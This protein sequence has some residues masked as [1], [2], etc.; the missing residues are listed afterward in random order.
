MPVR[1]QAERRA[2]SKA[3]KAVFLSAPDRRNRIWQMDFSDFETTTGG[4]WQICSV[5]EYVTK[6]TLACTASGTQTARD[7]VETLTAAIIEAEARMRRSLAD[8]QSDQL[9]LA[10]S[11]KRLTRMLMDSAEFSARSRG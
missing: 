9:Y 6:Y 11:C 3:R 10:I 1:Y 4:N 5:V 8:R 7:A 2:L